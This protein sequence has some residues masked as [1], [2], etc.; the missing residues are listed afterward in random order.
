M[1]DSKISCERL[2]RDQCDVGDWVDADNIPEWKQSAYEQAF[3]PETIDISPEMG[4]IGGMVPSVDSE[5]WHF[6]PVMN[7]SKP[8][9]QRS[10]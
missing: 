10:R 6:V 1:I 4:A 3:H 2:T 5:V 8:T 9:W 7:G